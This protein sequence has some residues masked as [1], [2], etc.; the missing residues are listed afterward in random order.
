MVDRFSWTKVSESE[1][2]KEPYGNELATKLANFLEKE[3]KFI[4]RIHRDYCGVGFEFS[5][6]KFYFGHVYD[7]YCDNDIK[8]F[9]KKDDL[10]EW[11]SKKNDYKM[12]GFD[13]KEDL[14]ETTEWMRNNQRIYKEDIQKFI[15]EVEKK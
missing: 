7:G 15:N 2:N 4:P 11:L 10:I 6:G 14:Y 13:S 3:G 1:F 12:S 5:N 9:D 8:T